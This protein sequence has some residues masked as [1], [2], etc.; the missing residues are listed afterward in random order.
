MFGRGGVV[1]AG[2]LALALLLSGCTDVADGAVQT[3]ASQNG[4]SDVDIVVGSFDFPESVLLADIYAGALSAAGFRAH[5]TPNLGTREVVMPALMNG[6]VQVVPEYAGSALAFI[7]LGRVSP[8]ADVTATHTALT[9]WTET[10]GLVAAEPAAAQNTNAI[11]VTQDV[12]Q[13]HHLR[14]IDDLAAVDQ[15]FVFGGPP[16]CP[17]RQY[18]LL[19]LERAYGLEFEGFVPTDAGGPLTRQAL[20]SGQ[21]D[22]GL[23]FSTDSSIAVKHLRVLADDRG[24]QPAENV[25]PLVSKQTVN[26]YGQRLLDTLDAVS[27]RLSTSTL[28]SLN[29]LVEDGGLDPGP[30]AVD[31]LRAQGL[32]P[33]GVPEPK[34]GREGA[35]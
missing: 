27:A 20:S 17:Q 35:R 30:V 33:R 23:L 34:T 5:V 29:G 21:I 19:G 26:R 31:W 32:V 2:C 15:D 1:P 13:R 8:T 28:R 16:E 4:S 14:T 9:H 11:V 24:L 22:V 6:L 18:C 10:R 7:S 3:P 12:A 25:T